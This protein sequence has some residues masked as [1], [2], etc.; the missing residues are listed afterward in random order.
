MKKIVSAACFL[1]IMFFMIAPSHGE[2]HLKFG[3]YASD[4]PSAL[5]K[6]FDPVLKAL[7]I[8]LTE[9][10]GEP[11]KIGIKFS[12]S[13]EGGIDDLVKGAID[14]SRFGPASYIAAKKANPGISIL[15]M[16]SQKG[17]KKFNGIIC[18]LKKSPINSPADL[19]GKT[20]A[21]GDKLSTIGRYLSQQYLVKNGIKA[22]SLKKFDYLKNHE[23]VGIAVA[24]GKFDAGALKESTFKKMVKKGAPLRALAEFPNVTKPWLAKAGM[25][26]RVEQAL[27]KSL[28][29]LKDPAALKVLK[30]AGFLEGGDGDYATIRD[31]IENNGVFFE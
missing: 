28:L 12:Q 17:K 27:K 26:K 9:T 11:V 4:K 13:Y 24:R 31:A 19:A 18:V 16:E 1:F 23:A 6:K 14:F 7:Q 25:D 3:L 20:F 21:F 10:L 15:A 22:D 29:E 8:K 5:K 2:V 30:K